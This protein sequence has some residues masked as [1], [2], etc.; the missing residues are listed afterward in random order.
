MP[1]R[2]AAP[3]AARHPGPLQHARGMRTQ[4]PRRAVRRTA[5][6]AAPGSARVRAIP[7]PRPIPS[8]RSRHV[9][10]PRCA[11]RES[12][13]NCCF[14]QYSQ[15]LYKET[16]VDARG[17]FP[18]GI[19]HA[20]F[21]RRAQPRWPIHPTTRATMPCRR[22]SRHAPHPAPLEHRAAT[23][24]GP[25]TAG[26]ACRASRPARPCSAP[27]TD[28]PGSPA[29]SAKTKTPAP[30]GVRRPG[31]GRPAA[32]P[33]CGGSGTGSDAESGPEPDRGIRGP[34]AA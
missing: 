20:S 12:R 22:R 32:G 3:R 15:I 25:E 6:R 13:R 9:E 1:R 4:G 23:A 5:S 21:P 24:A 31:S 10:P 8:H 29:C 26:G 30:D 19:P 16:V 27:G 28:P 7:A 11:R 34:A 14:I 18:E 2:P 17:E 33:A